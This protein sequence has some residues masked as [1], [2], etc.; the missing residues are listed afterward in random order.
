MKE[1]AVNPIR[2]FP[3]SGRT[4]CQT[5]EAGTLTIGTQKSGAVLTQSFSIGAIALQDKDGSSA[6]G[7]VD[8]WS[9]IA[10]AERIVEGDARALTEHGAALL[11]ATALI[12][13]AMTWPVPAEHKEEVNQ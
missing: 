6:V 8:F 13:A 2:E 9:A 5:T 1:I 3:I 7:P 4:L 11:L 10:F 12:G